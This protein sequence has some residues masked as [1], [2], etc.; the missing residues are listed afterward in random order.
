M[1]TITGACCK[2][3]TKLGL[4]AGAWWGFLRSA[5]HRSVGWA[6]GLVLT[7]CSVLHRTGP[8]LCCTLHV[9]W[10]MVHAGRV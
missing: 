9:G 4:G 7:C 6:E 3:T 8:A 1:R 10:E 2:K 5:R